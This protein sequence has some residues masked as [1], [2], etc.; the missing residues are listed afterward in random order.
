MIDDFYETT[1]DQIR[2]FVDSELTN[3][4]IIRVLDYFEDRYT[5]ITRHSTI[6]EDGFGATELD[7]MEL[8]DLNLEIVDALEEELDNAK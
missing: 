7:P 2:D 6:D 5:S 3:N 8:S 4:Q 1:L